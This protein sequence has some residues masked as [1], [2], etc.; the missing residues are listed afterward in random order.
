MKKKS[1]EKYDPEKT[2]ETIFGMMTLVGD[3]RS[4][5]KELGEEILPKYLNGSTKEK[6]VILKSFQEKSLEL[7]RILESESH[8]NLME[9][10]TPNYRML[11]QEMTSKLINEYQCSNEAEKALVEIVTNAYVRVLDNSRRLNNELECRDITQNRNTYISMLSKQVDR[12]NRQFLSA[13]LTLK[14]FKAP[15]IEM[16]VKATNAF[17][18]QNQQINIPN[19]EIIEP[20]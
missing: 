15:T 18:S 7:L 6:D 3:K 11:A 1:L 4:L 16:N 5:L 20:Q 10:F 13:L 14:Q 9:S 2:K 17:V 19:N 12:A 8:V